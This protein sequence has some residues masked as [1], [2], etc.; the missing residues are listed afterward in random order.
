MQG[1]TWKQAPILKEAHDTVKRGGRTLQVYR[2]GPRTRIV[3]WTTPQ[4][5]Y[6]VSHS[7]SLALTNRQMLDIAAGL[8]RVPG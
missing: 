5:V 3:A 1:T 6:W 2:A 8:V 4:G 7:L